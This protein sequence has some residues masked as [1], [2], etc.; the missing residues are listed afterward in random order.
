MIDR[1]HRCFWYNRI[2]F[3]FYFSG[4]GC[5]AHSPFDRAFNKMH[6]VVVVR[7]FFCHPKVSSLTSLGEGH[8]RLCIRVYM[9]IY[10]ISKC[11]Q[12]IFSILLDYFDSFFPYECDSFLGH[13]LLDSSVFFFT[14]WIIERNGET[15]LLLWLAIPRVAD[16]ARMP[17]KV[18]E[19]C[20]GL[21]F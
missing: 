4:K 17:L 16:F 5:G 2:T 7:R 3:H 15:S 9:I 19:D 11:F 10:H 8:I 13:V 21:S 18:F 20:L 14:S 12:A 1:F 6:K